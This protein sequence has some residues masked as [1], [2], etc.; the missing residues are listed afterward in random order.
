MLLTVIVTL[1]LNGTCIEKTVTD[2]A[3]LMQCGGGYAQPAIA[4]WMA[5]QGYTARGYV[6]RKWGCAIGGKGRSA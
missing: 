2:Q 6:L 5:D 4:Q 1:C 3:T